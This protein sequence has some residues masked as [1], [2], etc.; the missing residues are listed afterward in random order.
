MNAMPSFPTPN[1][2]QVTYQFPPTPLVIILIFL[3]SML[4]LPIDAQSKLVSVEEHRV[5]TLTGNEIPN[6]LGTPFSELSLVSIQRGKP[7]PIPFQFDD[8]NIKGGVY[9]EGSKVELLGDPNIFN[10]SDEL[11]FMI[12]DTGDKQNESHFFDGTIE[13]EISV[14]TIQGEVRYVYLVSG[15][16]LRSE[17]SYVRYS[18]ELGQLETD[19]YSLRVNKKNAL[20]WDEFTY[21]AFTGEQA[22]PLDTMKLRFHAGVITPLPKVTLNNK[23]FI[24]KLIAE[25]TGPIR[26]TSE[27]KVVVKFLKLPVFKVAMQI[28]FLPSSLIYDTHV[29]IPK[30][31]RKLVYNPSLSISLDGNEL[32]NAKIRVPLTP[33]LTGVADGQLS[34]EELAMMESGID[35]DNNWI[36]VS[37]EQNLDYFSFAEY[38]DEVKPTLGFFME[39]NKKKK[40]K[41]ER[42][43]GQQPNVGFMQKDFPKKGSFGLRVHLLFNTSLSDYPPETIA[44]HAKTPPQ[45]SVAL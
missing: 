20:N 27:F 38:T 32:E 36:W 45:V 19:H 40:D 44:Q 22:S 29:S 23:Q 18:A 37:T 16:R 30:I 14:T 26:A 4:S 39:D 5:V 17:N 41:P 8:I 10:E 13:A 43:R 31:R 25:K 21:H 28:H 7:R 2:S 12:S 34:E 35:I 3:L 11:L 24:A 9:L 1:A 6:V 15:S 33:E 42:F